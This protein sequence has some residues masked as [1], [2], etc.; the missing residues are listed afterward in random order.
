V[1]EERP[2]IAEAMYGPS[3]PIQSSVSDPRTQAIVDGGKAQPDPRFVNDRPSG[4]PPL[5][6]Q[7]PTR[8]GQPTLGPRNEPA[9]A[10]PFDAARWQAPENF[11]PDPATMQ[12]FAG[13]GVTQAQGEKL[14]A[15]HQ[16]AVA[17]QQDQLEKAW[18]DWHATTQRELGHQLPG[19]VDDIRDAVG[20]DRDASRF[21]QLLQWSGIEHDPS[22][23]KV[24]HRLST[25]GRRY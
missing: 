6:G 11:Q 23:L 12:E 25:G 9:G 19:M 10:Q 16:K 14:L 2:S 8:P 20:N 15:L 4:P 13:T 22:V 18:N 3:G 21:Y 24:L 1:S 17:A 7:I 5:P